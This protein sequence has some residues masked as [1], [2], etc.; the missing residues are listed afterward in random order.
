MLESISIAKAVAYK[1]RYELKATQELRGLGIANLVGCMFNCYTTT[2]SF[3][4]TAIMDSIGARTQ[5][6][7]IVSGMPQ[8]SDRSCKGI[9]RSQGCPSGVGMIQRYSLH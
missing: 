4:R 2:G 9:R 6:A 5:L 7:G 1:N 3:S 8:L